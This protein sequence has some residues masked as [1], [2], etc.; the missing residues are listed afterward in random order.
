MFSFTGNANADGAYVDLGFKAAFILLKCSSTTGNWYIFDTVRN[1]SNVVGEQL[2][3]NLANAGATVTTLDVTSRG[4]KLRL[5]GDPNAAQTY[6][7]YAVAAVNGKYS[8]SL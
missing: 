5:A 3:P 8:N 7:G 2:Y 6:I 4:F 1:T